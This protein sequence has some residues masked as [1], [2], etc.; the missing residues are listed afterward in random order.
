MVLGSTGN[1]FKPGNWYER[2]EFHEDAS[3][4]LGRPIRTWSACSRVCIEAIERQTGKP[5][6]VLPV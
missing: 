6:L 4:R 2:T 5:Q 1:W 3:G